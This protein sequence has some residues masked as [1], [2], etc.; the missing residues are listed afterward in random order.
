M[1]KPAGREVLISAYRSPEF[2]PVLCFG[3]GGVYAELLGD[4]VTRLLP[5]S[6]ADVDAMCSESRASILLGAFRNQE[7]ADR[8]AVI[9]VLLSVASAMEREP[10]VE[11]IEI[12]P[13]IVYRRGHGG[14]AVDALVGLR[15]T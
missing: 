4:V 12:N 11:L 8:E 13:F 5:V 7:P 9:D 10:D 15:P 3:L 6:R 2:G 1:M 14:V